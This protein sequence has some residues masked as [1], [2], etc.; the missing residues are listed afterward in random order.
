M[1]SKP[2]FSLDQVLSTFGEINDRLE[3]ACS[4]TTGRSKSK[5]LLLGRS[6]ASLRRYAMSTMKYKMKK[7]LH[8][9]KDLT[10]RHSHDTHP[11]TVEDFEK[12]GAFKKP[13]IPL[14]DL[15][16]FPLMDVRKG[17]CSIEGLKKHN[18][19]EVVIMEDRDPR[20]FLNYKKFSRMGLIPLSKHRN[21][22]DN[23]ILPWNMQ[24]LRDL[25][26]LFHKHDMK[27]H[28][29]FWGHIDDNADNPFIRE[30]REVLCPAITG[31]DDT[32]PLSIVHHEGEIMTFGDYVAGQYKK[33]VKD[34]GFDGLFLGDGL[35]G[36]RSFMDPL[37]TGHF[38][39]TQKGWEMFYA[40]LSHEVRKQGGKLMTFDVMGRTYKDA[41]ASGI[42]YKAILPHLDYLFFQSYGQTAWNAYMHI[43]TYTL[44]R[45]KKALKSIL[46]E[47]PKKEQKKLFYTLE[48]R[49]T[50]EGWEATC[51]AAGRQL[52]SLDPLA[53][54]KLGVWSNEMIRRLLT[55]PH[56]HSGLK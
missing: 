21:V 30:N 33:L 45:D 15:G 23:D 41:L 5:E 20:F 25:V 27:V 46:A 32:N 40:N 12:A 56:S 55:T 13:F 51:G 34:F 42:D 43:P 6:N 47:L 1:P 50:V 18:I 4:L 53:A 38:E 49:D 54:G 48:I 44:A 28:I 16:A 2:P 24:D 22:T 8:F 14:I 31:S 11:A 3:S 29:G 36:Y 10:G 17:L 39:Y 7:N 35:C 26:T 37:Q 19:S 9:L 52:R